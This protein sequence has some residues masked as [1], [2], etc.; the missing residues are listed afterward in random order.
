MLNSDLV[1]QTWTVRHLLR[2]D[3]EK[4]L[5]QIKNI[6][7]KYLEIAGTGRKSPDEFSRICLKYNLKIISVHQPPL[8]HDNIEALIED[9]IYQCEIYNTNIAVVSIDPINQTKD[10]YL[11]YANL[12][13]NTGKRLKKN[14]ITLCYHCYDH[15]L[16]NICDNDQPKSGLDI[17][18]ENTS[19]ESVLFEFDT[20][21]IVKSG[22]SIKDIF[23]KYGSR[24]KLLHLNDID[25][26]NKSTTL[27]DGIIVWE[28]FTN[29]IKDA[30]VLDWYILEHRTDDPL[31][32]IERSYHFFIEKYNDFFHV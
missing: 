21:F 15:D 27:G 10:A 31:P 3:V 4:T 20:H 13:S 22:S 5:N 7:F 9:T 16:R 24:C 25:A 12:C 23:I 28:D 19:P 29:I 18:Y 2:S 1:L 32:W 6:G 26:Q 30:S 17:I 8:D 11:K 14:G